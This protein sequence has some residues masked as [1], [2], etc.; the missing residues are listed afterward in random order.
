MNT[1]DNRILTTADFSN[2]ALCALNRGMMHPRSARDLRET[3]TALCLVKKA[4]VLQDQAS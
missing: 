2:L 1:T 3:M 4:R